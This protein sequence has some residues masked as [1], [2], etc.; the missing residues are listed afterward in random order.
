[1]AVGKREG[2]THAEGIEIRW[3]IAPDAMAIKGWDWELKK[4]TFNLSPWIKKVIKE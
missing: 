3:G 2:E 4:V 1:M